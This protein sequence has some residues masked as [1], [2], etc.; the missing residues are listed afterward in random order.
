MVLRGE[1]E[2]RERVKRQGAKA[3][4]QIGRIKTGR[5]VTGHRQPLCGKRRWRQCGLCY[6]ALFTAAFNDRCK[7]DRRAAKQTQGTRNLKQQHLWRQQA[8]FRGKTAGPASQLRQRRL[9]ARLITLLYV[10]VGL[11]R[12]RAGQSHAGQHA[13]RRGHLVGNDDAL[14]AD[15]GARRWPARKSF[16]RQA[17]QVQDKPEHG[18]GRRNSAGGEY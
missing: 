8:N 9:L 11:Q 4:R 13:S 17:R 6:E 1:I 3:T 14:T 18:A 16:E 12:P 7:Q 15:D 5:V 2:C 10:Q